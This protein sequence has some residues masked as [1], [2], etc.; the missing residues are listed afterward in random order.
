[1]V[2]SKGGRSGQGRAYNHHEE[3]TVKQSRYLVAQTL[4][5]TSWLSHNHWIT[6]SALT[7]KRF[8]SSIFIAKNS[9]STK[10]LLAVFDC[11]FSLQAS[12][13]PEFRLRSTSVLAFKRDASSMS[14]EKDSSL[15]ELL[16]SFSTSTST[17]NLILW[18]NLELSLSPKVRSNPLCC[19]WPYPALLLHSKGKCANTLIGYL[20]HRHVLCECQK[21]I[22]A[23]CRTPTRIAHEPHV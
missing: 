5:T 7:F 17:G 18:H 8:T 4:P 9:S 16:A 23:E 15:T 3:A 19:Q 10:L 12:N 1:M 22:K 11:S 21:Y 13:L 2:K 14:I 20:W 6:F